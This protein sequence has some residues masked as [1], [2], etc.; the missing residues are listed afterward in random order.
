[1]T[2][3]FSKHWHKC[4]H[5]ESPGAWARIPLF[6]HDLVQKIVWLASDMQVVIVPG[7][8]AYK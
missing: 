3:F 4:S 1:M 5:K 7:R 2:P 6:S 8:E